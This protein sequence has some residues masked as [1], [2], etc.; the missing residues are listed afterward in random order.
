MVSLQYT[1]SFVILLGVLVTVHE[2]GHF[3]AAKWA[4]VKV[5]KFSIGFGP[6]I[7]G[8]RR[9][10]TEYQVAWVPLGGFVRMA[11]ELPEDDVSPD[12]L[13]RSFMSAAWWKRAIIVA[14]GP[15]MNLVFP[16]L[17]FFFVFLGD[18]QGLA[19]QVGWVEP[20]Y[21]AAAAGLRPGDLVTSVD[22][23]PIYEFGEIARTLRNVFDRDVTVKVERD[24]KPL[25]FTLRP[26]RHTEAD[27]GAGKTQRGLLGITSTPRAPI[28]GV[29]PG[30]AAEAAGLRT[31]D[32]V[33]TVD[34]KPIP[35][36][37]EL[38][39]V[40]AAAPG[41]LKLQV[42]RSH[43]AEVAGATLVLPELVALTVEKQPGEGP[44]VLGGESA[45][46]YV[47]TVFPGTPADKAGLKRGDRLLGLDGQPMGS[48]FAFQSR[49]AEL[50]TDGF[51]LSWR[52]GAE[53]KHQK[54]SQAAEHYVDELKNDAEKLEFGVRPRPTFQGASEVLASGPSMKRITIHMGPVEAL[55]ASLRTVPEAIA[56]VASSIGRIFT[57]EVS[58]KQVGGPVTLFLAAGKS[59]EA[60]LSVYVQNMAM[61]S[62]NL[63]L[64]NLFPIPVLD[65][66]ALLAAFWEGIRRRPIP[67]KAREYANMVG[68]AMLVMLMVAILFGNDLPKLF[69]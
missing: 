58:F 60:G 26:H 2:A 41:P 69:R 50:G 20:G 21:P 45:D 61:I 39:R 34:G 30:S 52:S 25:S 57:G 65:G 11:G 14:A 17:V 37:L 59:A 51:E 8:F 16:V 27:Q 3:L 1:L 9:G 40:L 53:E 36:E 24:G 63:G 10:E 46:L 28:I 29:P 15:A 44:A 7:F 66:F 48:F 33:L 64:V 54:V 18:H 5:L 43:L 49:L 35:D 67:L 31:F 55:K 6:R 32:R 23:E 38:G 62:V 56:L 47:W 22:G 19:P 13:R 12:D 68:L 42:V 4:G